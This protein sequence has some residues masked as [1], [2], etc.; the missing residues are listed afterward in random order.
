MELTAVIEAL[1][2]PYADLA[3]LALGL[4]AFLEYVFPPFPGDTVTLAGAVLVTAYGYSAVR[5]IAAVLLGGLVGGAVDF[6]IGVAAGR[7]IARSRTRAGVRPPGWTRVGII[8][9]AVRGAE[10]VSESFNR[11]GEA[12]IAINRFL[13]GIRG[14]LFVAAGM[15]GMRFS[16]V[17]LWATLSSLAWHLLLLAAGMAVGTQVDRLETLFGKYGVVAWVLLALV[18]AGLFVRYW[19]RRRRSRRD[20]ADTGDRPGAS[21]AV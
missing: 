15:A 17:M 9:A 2:G 14:F 11:H 5:V 6:A 19:V 10:R 18:A 1:T 3:T 20:G 8:A 21:G 12:Y 7:V 16:R 13:P 4:A